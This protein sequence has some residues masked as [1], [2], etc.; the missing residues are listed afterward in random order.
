[1]DSLFFT[2]PICKAPTLL[3]P[4]AIVHRNLNH[5]G[6][7]GWAEVASILPAT[8]S[9]RQPAANQFSTTTKWNSHKNINM[10]LRFRLDG[11]AFGLWTEAVP[12]WGV[13]GE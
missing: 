8:T 9:N 1:M 10:Q 6:R 13:E 2:L 5:P 4:T 7:S 11:T 3:K 12:P